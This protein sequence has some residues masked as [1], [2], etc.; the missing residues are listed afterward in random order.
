[1]STENK[2]VVHLQSEQILKEKLLLPFIIRINLCL[3]ELM[4]YIKLIIMK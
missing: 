1:M 3:N 2:G 4:K